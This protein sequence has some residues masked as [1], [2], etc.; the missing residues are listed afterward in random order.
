MSGL[1][2]IQALEAGKSLVLAE[3]VEG[4]HRWVFK[5]SSIAALFYGIKGHSYAYAWIPKGAKDPFDFKVR[6]IPRQAAYAFA[7]GAIKMQLDDD[8]DYDRQQEMTLRL[9]S[10]GTDGIQEV[11]QMLHA[12]KDLKEAQKAA[13]IALDSELRVREA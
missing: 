8:S 11:L 3:T 13:R 10:L 2:M 6:G 7:A 12:A 9:Q 5:L 1:M 4:P